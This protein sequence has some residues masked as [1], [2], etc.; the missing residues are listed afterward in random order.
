MRMHLTCT[1]RT[2]INTFW[3]RNRAHYQNAVQE[4]TSDM[5]SAPVTLVSFDVDGT[6]IRS[7]GVDANRL[8]KDAF[9]YGFKK[10]FDIDTHIDVIEHHG[11]TDPLI[12]VKVLAHHSIPVQEA[13]SKLKDVEAA[14]V[15]Y[16]QQHV[17]SVSV[18]LELLPGVKDLLELLK[19]Q[20]N[21]ATCLVTGNLEPIGWAKMQA[22]GIYHMFSD[23]HFGGF[24]SDYCSGDIES[25]W[26]RDRMQLVRIA[27]ERCTANFPGGII[28]HFHVGDTPMD[29]QAALGAGVGAV[30]VSTGTYSGA[31][32]LEAGGGDP[33]CVVLPD[34]TDGAAVLRVLGLAA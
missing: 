19:A 21:V 17:S 8:H 9:S 2:R 31:Q 24:G 33:R 10:I 16:A 4:I 28:S 23:A 3:K 15:E 18:G 25:D 26:W 5:P 6:L 30:G 7:I 22:L 12:I 29:V 27:A 14:M 1:S 20:D 13:M 34:L 11:G 32:L